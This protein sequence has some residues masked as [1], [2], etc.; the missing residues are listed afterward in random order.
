M[1]HNKRSVTGENYSYYLKPY[2]N[3]LFFG[4]FVKV[5]LPNVISLSFDSQMTSLSNVIKG[6][7][8]VLILRLT[9]SLN[10][11]CFRKTFTSTV[12]NSLT[13]HEHLRDG[14]TLIP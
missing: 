6:E 9:D 7:V 5:R 2:I 11:L 8:T 4:L 14:N 13:H 12:I 3:I 10:T 1:A